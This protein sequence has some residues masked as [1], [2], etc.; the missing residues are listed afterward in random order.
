LELYFSDFPFN[1]IQSLS[2]V[3]PK[4]SKV[5]DS[6]E[7]REEKLKYADVQNLGNMIV[8]VYEF[9]EGVPAVKIGSFFW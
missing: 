4:L 8:Q 3:K 5:Y 2:V 7:S 9:K 1:E 6:G